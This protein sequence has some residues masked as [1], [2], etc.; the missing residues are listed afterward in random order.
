MALR[1][2]FSGGGST[3][4]SFRLPSLGGGQSEDQGNVTPIPFDE[5]QADIQRLS[6]NYN[7]QAQVGADQAALLAQQ[8][9]TRASEA[10]ERLD[11]S[12]I[13][14]EEYNTL[15]EIAE[16]GYVA[17]KPNFVFDVLDKFDRTVGLIRLGV[18]DVSGADEAKGKEITAGD[19]WSMLLGRKAALRRDL[20]EDLIGEDARASGGTILENVFGWEPAEFERKSESFTGDEGFFENITGGLPAAGAW[21]GEAVGRG[22]TDFL[23]ETVLDPTTYLTFGLSAV[24]KKAG[25]E[26][27]Q[28][29]AGRFV[30]KALDADDVASLSPLLAR[31]RN[32]FDL[33]VEDIFERK[34]A[35]TDVMDEFSLE[36]DD[37][38]LIKE[39]AIE[40]ATEKAFADLTNAVGKSLADR[41][42]ASLPDDWIKEVI[43]D[44][45]APNWLAGGARLVLPRVMGGKGVQG[46]VLIPGSRGAGRQVTNT[47]FRDREWYARLASS[48]FGEAARNIKKRLG[49]EQAQLVAARAGDLFAF[50]KP[51][52]VWGELMDSTGLKEITTNLGAEAH[53]L[54]RIADEVGEDSEIV[55]RQLVEYIEV[56]EVPVGRV[57]A[58]T[59][60]DNA[61]RDFVAASVQSMDQI[62]QTMKRFD[63]G[64]G[65]IKNYVPRIMTDETLKVMRRLAE[66]APEIDTST[67]GGQLL[68]QY[69]ASFGR[70]PGGARQLGESVFQQSREIG[71][72]AMVPL[73]GDTR[74]ALVDSK[75]LRSQVTGGGSIPVNTLNADLVRA[76]QDTISRNGLNIRLTDEFAFFD[77]DP[78]NLLTSYYQGMMGSLQQRVMIH[79]WQKAGL[80]KSA[81]KVYDLQ[82]TLEQIADKFFKADPKLGTSG[83]DRMVEWMKTIDQRLDDV[84]DD[85]MGNKPVKTEKVDLGYG[86]EM[87]LPEGIAEL[88][89]MR[90]VLERTR[91]KVAKAR[92]RQDDILAKRQVMVNDLI[93]NG[94]HPNLAVDIAMA[95]PDELTDLMDE[96]WDQALRAKAPEVRATAERLA[97]DVTEESDRTT[98]RMQAAIDEAR[99]VRREVKLERA[100]LRK[101]WRDRY[102]KKL[103]VDPDDTAHVNLGAVELSQ[104]GEV[105]RANAER[106]Y[107]RYIDSVFEELGADATEARRRLDEVKQYVDSSEFQEWLANRTDPNIRAEGVDV[108]KAARQTSPAAVKLEEFRMW[109]EE[110]ALQKNAL[111][112]SKWV[113]NVFAEAV[114]LGFPAELLPSSSTR[115]RLRSHPGARHHELTKSLGAIDYYFE[116]D[117]LPSVD[118][119]V[120]RGIIDLDDDIADLANE[121][122]LELL[123]RGGNRL[124]L[125][126]IPVD[127]A[128]NDMYSK[129]GS[130]GTQMTRLLTALRTNDKGLLRTP[131]VQDDFFAAIEQLGGD[132]SMFRFVDGTI[133]KLVPAQ[134]AEFPTLSEIHTALKTS[135]Y[136]DVA[137]AVADPSRLPKNIRMA[138]EADGV[139]EHIATHNQLTKTMAEVRRMERQAATMGKGLEKMNDA[140]RLFDQKVMPNLR[141]VIKGDMNPA[142]FRRS[143]AA[144]EGNRR[145]LTDLG[146]ALR[147]GLPGDVFDSVMETALFYEALAAT[148]VDRRLLA[149]NRSLM[150]GKVLG[151][152]Q[153]SIKKAT[154][155]ADN[156]R[157]ELKIAEGMQLGEQVADVSEFLDILIDDLMTEAVRYGDDVQVVPYD[158]LVATKG[159]LE[160]LKRLRRLA[161][162]TGVADPDTFKPSKVRTNTPGFRPIM[163]AGVGGEIVTGRVARESVNLALENLASNL[164]AA[165]TP[166]GMEVFKSNTATFLNAY[167]KGAATV[168]RPTFHLRNLVGAVWNNQIAD[169][170][171]REYLAL[172]S[173]PTR[174]LN[175]LRQYNSIDQAMA[176][177]PDHLK[178]A[179]E[180]M[181]KEG[182]L[183]TTF[184]RE[185]RRVSA[186]RSWKLTP[187]G[188]AEDMVDFAPFRAGG[189]A[190][191]SIEIQA[192]AAVFYRYFDP[193][194][195][196]DSA[197]L[198]KQM[199]HAVHFNYQDL[200]QVERSIKRLVPFF[201]WTRRNIPLQLQ[202]LLERP[203]IAMRYQHL[204]YAVEGQWGQDVEAD[205]FPESQ[206]QTGWVASTGVV[207]NEDSPFWARL[208]FD[209]DIPMKQI[210]DIN[211][212]SW[213]SWGNLLLGS[214]GPQ[215][216][217]A[218]TLRSQSEFPDVVAPSGMSAVLRGL[219]AV[220]LWDESRVTAAGDVMIPRTTRT[221]LETAVPFFREYEELT[222]GSNDPT[223]QAKLGQLEDENNWFERVALTLGK[224]FGVQVQTPSDASSQFFAG[225]QEVQNLLD[226]EKMQGQNLETQK[227][228]YDIV[229]EILASMSEGAQD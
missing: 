37:L 62:Y 200:T 151:P 31:V 115:A 169:V 97:R 163:D 123:V 87:S 193:N 44:P 154:E 161:A 73:V 86:M 179:F 38:L 84:A 52:R 10:L 93:A 105:F 132:P 116:F 20:G 35:D 170:G 175:K 164:Q 192:R 17:Q 3:S 129:T 47:I 228:S 206:Y 118:D 119:M 61:A 197:A 41:D 95:Q 207:L 85:L 127:E 180:W 114:E 126:A 174:F 46:G 107:N 171:A 23:I 149:A 224:G 65:E 51:E 219:A 49:T 7:S 64:I 57:F 148:K 104:L 187:F 142:T 75:E 222:V 1:G 113:D 92:A 70:G 89:K 2:A 66:A 98:A 22:I 176:T 59:N 79:E 106:T 19:Y 218:I 14:G 182:V 135:G 6:R 111:E 56:G 194:N 50:N 45:D 103:L 191:E 39:E 99:T 159:D 24:G 102:A 198:A 128:I 96:M 122:E 209:P 67:R 167:W 121:M 81:D 188:K 30:R 131:G 27:A 208:L 108:S 181:L 217:T 130:F 90:D 29:A 172:G 42:F 153:H 5:D 32:Q 125:K 160:N 26:A 33:D 202:V 156:L 195:P 145:Q 214:L 213:E 13:S 91:A 55:L 143:L 60:L 117:A 136:A 215:F 110:S 34:L 165:W 205:L 58:D 147:Q 63:E 173:H 9:A 227:T 40:E 12:T 88:E 185:F 144:V 78:L 43:A 155:Y 203:G 210:L 120:A 11:P 15:A 141:K 83:M 158:R 162:R 186:G 189:V 101:Q 133:R 134:A 72:S 4:F 196:V 74:Y 82:R 190:M 137:E 54:A 53:R 109:L 77:N 201:V 204:A 138:L 225:S 71:R 25:L 212:L 68:A 18:L 216:T 146:K 166:N 100:G 16:T 221:L 211:P 178:P 223:R 69:I 76:V 140:Q 152:M 177:L 199:V 184:A 124:Q 80:I 168:A 229:E 48:G 183:D 94:V 157:T 150:Q 112:A 226:R 139:P 8:S 220:G 28:A 21:T 36:P